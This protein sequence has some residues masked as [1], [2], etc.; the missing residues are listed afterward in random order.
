MS[1]DQKIIT[2]LD[3][4]V[5]IVALNNPP[6]NAL[7]S[8]VRSQ[9]LDCLIK[10]DRD[11]AIKA[12]VLTGHGRTFTGGAD[13]T[14]FG[15]PPQEP[16]LPDLINTIEALETPVIAAMHGSAY[17]GGC[18][19]AL[20]AHFRVATSDLKMALPEVKLGLLPG[21]GGTQRLPRLVAMREALTIIV[22]GNP[23]SAK[24]AQEI[25]LIDAVFEADLIGNA[26]RFARDRVAEN[27]PLRRVSKLEDTLIAARQAREAFESEAAALLKR[28]RGLEAPAACVASLRNALDLPFAEG[29]AAERQFFIQLRDG[30]QSKAQRHL[31][32]AERAAL[33]V[34]GVPADTPIRPVSKVVVLGAGTMGGGIAMAFASAGFHVT[35]V[36]PDAEA[37][38][39]GMA[40]V[41]A[42]YRATHKRGGISDRA[43]EKAL[44]LLQGASSF[45]AVSDADLII[46]AVFEDLALKQKIFADLDRRA[47]PGAILASNTSTLDIDTIAA[48]TARPQDVMGMHFFSPANVMRLLENV[49]GKMTAPDVLATAIEVGKRINKMPVTVG[50][51]YGFV[52]NRMLHARSGQIE[53][54]LLEGAAPKD[55]DAVATSFG[56]LMGPCAVGDLAGLDVGWRIRQERGRVAI[57]ADAI[58]TMGRFGQKTGKGYYLYEAGSRTPLPDPAIDALIARLAAE[59][60]IKRR[61][62]DKQEIEERLI[63]PLINE[64]ARILAEGIAER[65]SDIDLIWI[66]GYGF[67]VGRGGPMFHAEQVGLATVVERLQH[68]AKAS[69]DATLQPAP[70][71]V[72]LAREGKSFADA[73]TR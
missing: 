40:I 69:G 65:A 63:Y 58:C 17:G 52:G 34:K 3:G 38:K 62:I 24:K 11:P 5:L 12:I 8:V 43:L 49:R 13:I 66:N 19:I 72:A 10:A 9:L 61:S 47:K 6:V 59:H 25:G 16:A 60:G 56:F 1:P 14:E 23:I 20:G 71:L 51:C 39:R 57:V 31:F 4:D 68:Y 37:L 18:E 33:K 48:A 70:L 45:D 42:N 50:V 21:A 28:S 53:S 27:H 2:H 41:E 15:K 44:G 26:I 30:V 22:S 64:G 54:L 55:I 67:P 29:L 7:S 35:M 73:P 32:F 46:E 36:D